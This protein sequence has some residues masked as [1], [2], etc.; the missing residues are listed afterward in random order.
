MI[1]G[2]DPL[3][4]DL[5]DWKN[6]ISKSQKMGNINVDHA[7]R[8]STAKQQI[9]ER[10]SL[11]D[12]LG[13]TPEEAE[14]IWRAEQARRGEPTEESV[15]MTPDQLNDIDENVVMRL[16]DDMIRTIMDGK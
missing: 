13:G 7:Q 5:S 8:G 12:R 6:I 15:E 2:I 11:V 3:L 9:Q 14:A 10:G 4:S 16:V 1:K